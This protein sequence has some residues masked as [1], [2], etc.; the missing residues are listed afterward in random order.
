MSPLPVAL[1]G[2]GHRAATVYAPLLLGPLSDR[3]RLVGIVARSD[4]R[5][6]GL[7]Q[8]LDLPWGLDL[9]D[10]ADWG[11]RGLILCASAHANG[12]LGL[13]AAS[14]GL[15]LLLETPLALELP[16]AIRL[17]EALEGALVEVAEQ[18][19]R[20]GD[21]LLWRRIVQEGWLGRVQ[22]VASDA[23]GYRY[24]AAS[25]ARAILG[26]P[27][28]RHAVG[29][30]TVFDEDH[31]PEAL[32]AGTLSTEGGAIYQVRDG[33]ALHRGAWQ[34]G[35]WWLAGTGGSLRPDGVQRRDHGPPPI[36]SRLEAGRRRWSCGPLEVVDPLPH[37]DADAAAVARCLLDWLA[38]I[39]G[40]VTE[41]AWSVDDA[42]RDLAW[43]AAIER[44]ATL[45]VRV[46]VPQLLGTCRFLGGR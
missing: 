38:R 28:A 37:L 9:S 33:E 7:A 5:V 42:L 11:A 8:G 4:Y 46:S 10:A 41:T 45:G 26:R 24:H 39:D 22:A 27:H 40:R 3:F 20:F 36:E 15:P 19:P 18:N 30:R 16:D 1:V 35:G 17:A 12:P 25:V 34:R 43:C 13:Q 44:A 32:Y 21:T 23:A 29:L 14:L 2:A 6:P 31:G